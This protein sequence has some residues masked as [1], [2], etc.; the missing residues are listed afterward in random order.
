MKKFISFLISIT[1]VATISCNSNTTSATSTAP[2]ETGGKD[3][4]VSFTIDGTTFKGKVSTQYFGSNK[5]TDNFSVVCQQDEPLVLLQAT[6]ANEKD[7]AS[8]GL[9]PKGFDGYKVNTGQFDLTLTPAGGGESFVATSK[10]TGAIKIENNK[11]VIS[12]MRLF[13]REGKEK[14]VNGTIGF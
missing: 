10:T 5:E 14:V 4:T 9:T 11:I 1:V 7:A 2:I 6:F 8:S 3:K 13:N 12:N